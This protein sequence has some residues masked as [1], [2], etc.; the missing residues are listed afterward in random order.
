MYKSQR[1]GIDGISHQY[2]PPKK[3][4]RHSSPKSLRCRLDICYYLFLF[5]FYF[6][7][8][9][10]YKPVSEKHPFGFAQLESIF[11]LLKG[12]MFIA[13]MISLITNNVQLMLNGGNQVNH[14]QISIFEI[15]LTLFSCMVLL[16][17]M[18]LNKKVSSP[19]I[20]ME[21]YGWKIDVLGSI[22]VSIAFFLSTFMERSSFSIFTPYF[23]QVVAIILA[24]FMLPEPIRMVV[25]ALRSIVLFSPDDEM[26]EDIKERTKKVLLNYQFDPVFY[27]ITKTGRRIWVSIYFTTSHDTMSFIELELANKEL[28]DSLKDT[29]EDCFVELIPNV[30][31][32][33]N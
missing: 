27:D 21:I 18:R 24:L 33:K 26:I 32:N 10:F 2:R 23:D 25:D 22:G 19:T 9:L 4:C 16:C 28:L 31:A 6:V 13:V 7:I 30:L 14:M 12:F 20:D 3:A 29:Y 1:R 5:V 11:I 8:P 17:L 15:V